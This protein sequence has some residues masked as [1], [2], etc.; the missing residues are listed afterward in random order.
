MASNGSLTRA[1]GEVTCHL[2]SSDRR[3]DP[4]AR[5][6]QDGVRRRGIAARMKPGEG[7]VSASR[8]WNL[9]PEALLTAADVGGRLKVSPRQVQRLGVPWGEGSIGGLRLSPDG[10]HAH[11]SSG[12]ALPTNGRELPASGR[13]RRGR[14]PRDS[15]ATQEVGALVCGEQ[16]PERQAGKAKR[17]NGPG[18][19][20]AAAGPDVRLVTARAR[21][22]PQGR[23]RD[24]SRHSPLRRSAPE[25]HLRTWPPILCPSH[26]RSRST[27]VPRARLCLRAVS[28]APSLLAVAGRVGLRAE[29]RGRQARTPSASRGLRSKS[30]SR[31]PRPSARRH[32]RQPPYPGNQVGRRKRPRRVSRSLQTQGLLLSGGLPP[33]RHA[34]LW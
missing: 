17:V 1:E 22:P 18:E 26:R 16:H 28:P 24:G 19:V 30:D 3:R 14:G 2:T 6:L 33:R 13:P 32:G 7:K 27:S 21:A 34:V 23:D 11:S 8:F 15:C 5:R 4:P 9:P 25:R 31:S 12:V 20:L 10:V 29:R